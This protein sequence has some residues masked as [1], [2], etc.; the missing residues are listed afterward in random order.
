M[1]CDSQAHTW[2]I[3]YT[4]KDAQGEVKPTPEYTELRW[5]ERELLPDDLSPVATSMIPL[6]PRQ[7]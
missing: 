6:W 7:T 2:E 1:I 5:C 3:I 4:I